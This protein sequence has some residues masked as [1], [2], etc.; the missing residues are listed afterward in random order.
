MRLNPPHKKGCGDEQKSANRQRYPD[1]QELNGPVSGF[2]VL[3]QRKE[4][5]SHAENHQQQ[6]DSNDDFYHGTTLVRLVKM[7]MVTEQRCK[8]P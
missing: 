2:A 8:L 7:P 3:N 6:Q 5:C 1:G 4:T